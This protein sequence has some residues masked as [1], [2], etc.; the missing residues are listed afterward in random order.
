MRIIKKY[1]L[2][3]KSQRLE[4][5]CEVVILVK[6]S[7]KKSLETVFEAFHKIKVEILND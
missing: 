1:K 6:K 7:V 5:D 3:I 4:M 2:L